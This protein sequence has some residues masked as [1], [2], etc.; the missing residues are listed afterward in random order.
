MYHVFFHISGYPKIVFSRFFRAPFERYR[1]INFD[2]LAVGQ[3]F[4]TGVKRIC[5]IC[6]PWIMCHFLGWRSRIFSSGA[7]IVLCLT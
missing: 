4:P 3:L 1:I 5:L 2:R 7:R 6:M